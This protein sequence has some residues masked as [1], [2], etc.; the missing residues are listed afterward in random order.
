MQ[1]VATKKIKHV[2]VVYQ[3]LRNN[4]GGTCCVINMLITGAHSTSA[5]VL[6]A[7]TVSIFRFLKGTRID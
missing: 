2:Y 6:K 4:I 5:T 7:K 1:E 3:G